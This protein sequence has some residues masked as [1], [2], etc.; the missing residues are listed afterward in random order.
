[1]TVDP[2]DRLHGLTLRPLGQVQNEVEHRSVVTNYAQKHEAVPDRILKAQV[3]PNMENDTNRKERAARH[4][5]SNGCGRYCG[6]A[7]AER[8]RAPAHDK[9]SPD[10]KAVEASG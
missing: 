1:M 7:V 10:R 6:I 4:H 8:D 9:I 5:E 3:L 2:I